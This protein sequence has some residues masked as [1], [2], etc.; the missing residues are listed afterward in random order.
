MFLTLIIPIY[1]VE[2][3]L[4][5]CLDSVAASPLDCWVAGWRLPVMRDSTRPRANG[6]GSWMLTI[7][8]IC[9]M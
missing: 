2:P 9:A 8:S 3:Y 6:Y 4:R 1:K 5:E 7:W